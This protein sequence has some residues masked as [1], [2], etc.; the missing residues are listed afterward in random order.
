MWSDE[1][2]PLWQQKVKHL[3]ICFS[4]FFFF[5]FEIKGFWTRKRERSTLCNLIPELCI[6]PL[7]TNYIDH[8]RFIIIDGARWFGPA[9][10]YLNIDTNN[11]FFLR[12][13]PFLWKKNVRNFASSLM[14]ARGV[15]LHATALIELNRM[16]PVARRFFG[17]IF[18]YVCFTV[19]C[20]PLSLALLWKQWRSPGCNEDEIVLVVIHLILIT[21]LQ[22]LS[23]LESCSLYCWPRIEKRYYV[24][25]LDYNDW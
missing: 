22:R 7:T 3:Y 2:S 13:F 4:V 15:S 24:L 20:I 21:I 5:L 18:V 19:W 23:C 12:P 10:H 14:C 8:V 1:P 16:C 9:K 25:L 6:W 17:R 11:F